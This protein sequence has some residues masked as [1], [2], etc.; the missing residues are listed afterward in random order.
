MIDYLARLTMGL[1]SLCFFLLAVGL[2]AKVI[3]LAL[4]FGWELL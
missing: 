4:S 2:I 1:L 3:W